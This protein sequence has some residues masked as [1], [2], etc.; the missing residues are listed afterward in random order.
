M[1]RSSRLAHDGSTWLS[2]L[3]APGSSRV[4]MVLVVLVS[5]SAEC[6]ALDSRYDRTRSTFNG[7]GM[8][9]AADVDAP[10]GQ[11]GRESRVLALLADREGKLEI[12]DD[13]PSRP[14]AGVQHR[15]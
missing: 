14:R 3:S 7:P 6:V 1:V 9:V 2:W 10:A 12:G 13:H 5:R 11:A 4:P 15:H 8:R